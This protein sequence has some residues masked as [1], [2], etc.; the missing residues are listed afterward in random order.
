M[1]PRLNYPL[2]PDP[3]HAAVERDAYH[4]RLIVPP[5]ASVFQLPGSYKKS[6]FFLLFLSTSHI[7]AFIAHPNRSISDIA[8]AA[9]IDG[10]SFFI[11]FSMAY[12]RTHRWS[13][14]EITADRFRLYSRVFESETLKLDFP[15]SEILE[16]RLNRSNGK[17]ILR[18]HRQEM[19]EI[20]I[21][22]DR[23]AAGRQRGP[24]V[25]AGGP[26]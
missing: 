18:V 7:W 3:A 10:I 11:L 2:L 22:V 20:F 12:L 9:W 5:V 15:R 19:R 16:I 25:Q 13:T 6:F 17:L 26:G 4:F 1:V 14:F 23:I 8:G 24:G 21:S